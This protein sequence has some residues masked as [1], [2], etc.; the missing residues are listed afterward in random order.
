MITCWEITLCHPPAPFLRVDKHV[1]WVY[2]KYLT[3]HWR[4]HN[5]NLHLL[6]VWIKWSLYGWNVYRFLLKGTRSINILEF[7]FYIQNSWN[8][9]SP[10][11]IK[12]NT[13]V[14]NKATSLHVSL[15]SAYWQSSLSVQ[16]NYE[17]PISNNSLNVIIS[18]TIFAANWLKQAYEYER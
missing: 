17:S 3:Q 1:S 10:L 8:I 12:F 11:N 9:S 18:S 5:I 15:V 16:I 7:L 14:S 2:T 13:H 4:S 6:L